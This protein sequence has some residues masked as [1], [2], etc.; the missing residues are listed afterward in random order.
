LRIGV[1][2]ML[3]RIPRRPAANATV[4]SVRSTVDFPTTAARVCAAT[5]L[6]AVTSRLP[7]ALALFALAT[8]GSLS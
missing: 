5:S 4:G 1:T 8:F 6:G 2:G 3:S 7:I